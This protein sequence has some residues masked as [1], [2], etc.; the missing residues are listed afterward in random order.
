[1][2]QRGFRTFLHGVANAAPDEAGYNRPDCFVIDDGAEHR[3]RNLPPR[4]SDVR[5]IPRPASLRQLP[6][7]KASPEGRAI[8]VR[9]ASRAA[10]G[11]WTS[12][13]GRSRSCQRLEQGA[14]FTDV[15]AQRTRLRMKHQ[16]CTSPR[17]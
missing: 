1:M 9:I 15:K 13:A 8:R 4:G 6:G 7:A 17:S 16:L 14:S 11:F 5:P 12:S 2:T 10:P 3:R